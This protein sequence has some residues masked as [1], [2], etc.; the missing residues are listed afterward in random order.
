MND[1][2]RVYV[3]TCQP[4]HHSLELAGD[5]IEFEVL[6]LNGSIQR[7]DL[8]PAEFV[9]PAVNRVE[10]TFGEVCARAK[11][12]H[13]LSHEHW[14]NAASNCAIVPP[15]ITHER[16]ALELQRAGIDRDFCSELAK[17]IWQPRRIP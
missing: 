16:V 5:I 8:L 17:V 1:V 10:K 13:L 12:L 2:H 6:A 7:H 9:A 14:R 4:L 11:E 3:H 15:C